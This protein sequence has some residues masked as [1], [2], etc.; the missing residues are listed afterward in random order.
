MNKITRALLVV[1]IILS[2]YVIY[3]L[4][5]Y[6]MINNASNPYYVFPFF[7]FQLIDSERS[8]TNFAFFLTVFAWIAWGIGFIKGD[9]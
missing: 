2:V 7:F 4:G 5:Y 6:Q 1:A 3:L 8:L 9:E